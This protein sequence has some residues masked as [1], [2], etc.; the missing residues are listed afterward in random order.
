[1]AQQQ[2]P[3]PQ[4]FPYIRLILTIVLTSFIL[5]LFFSKKIDLVVLLGLL[6]SLLSISFVERLLTSI[7]AWDSWIESRLRNFCLLLSK[8]TIGRKIS[9]IGRKIL[10]IGAQNPLH[11]LSCVYSNNSGHDLSYSYWQ[12]NRSCQ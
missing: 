12:C 1:M 8:F 7:D 3:N 4:P 9:A 2:T 6:L 10:A 11:N 5:L